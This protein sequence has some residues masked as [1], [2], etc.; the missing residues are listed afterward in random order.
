M[1]ARVD[2]QLDRARARVA[3][4]KE[5]GRDAAGTLG[6]WNDVSLALSNA[7]AVASLLS[8]VH[9][10][11]A[12]RSRGEKGEQDAH[13]LLTEIGLDRELFDVL[14]AVDAAELDEGGRR[15]L[16]LS[17]R[18]FRRAGVDQDESVRDRLRALAERQTEVAQEFSKNIR[19]GVRTVS[20]DPAQLD[21]LPEDFLDAHQPGE[22]GKVVVTTEYPDY[23]PYMTFGRDREARARARAASTRTA[24]GP[25]TTRCSRSCSSC[26]AS[27]PRCSA[28]PT[29]RRTTPRSR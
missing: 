29:G 16:T 4:L 9:P 20:L 22:D 6:L 3:D 17:L 23:V 11:E 10:D 8:N 14:D 26:A 18:D 5:G 7:F 28:T 27:T 21:G 1:G 15:V 12:V 2:D 19:D 25:R 13:K 24:P